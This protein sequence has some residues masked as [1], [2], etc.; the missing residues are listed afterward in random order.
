MSV[1]RV[2]FPWALLYLPQVFLPLV[3]A[4]E[5]L[6]YLCSALTPL[7]GLLNLQGQTGAANHQGPPVCDVTS[8]SK[9]KK[10][11]EIEEGQWP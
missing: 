10:Q 1:C 3:N 7:M 9:F 5:G 2:S 8:W 6:L 11:Q 4:S